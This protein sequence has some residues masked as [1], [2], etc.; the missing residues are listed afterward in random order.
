M[1]FV[2]EQNCGWQNALPVLLQGG[3]HTAGRCLRCD[4]CPYGVYSCYAHMHIRLLGWSMTVHMLLL[5]TGLVEQ[6]YGQHQTKTS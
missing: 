1:F 2:C 6:I 5:Q 4:A 3:S